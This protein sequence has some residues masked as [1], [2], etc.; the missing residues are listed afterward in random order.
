[1][2]QDFRIRSTDVKPNID[3]GGYRASD[4]MGSG[5]IPH[6]F[7]NPKGTNTDIQ[8]LPHLDYKSTIIFLLLF[9][10]GQKMICN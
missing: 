7:F 6:T 10:L 5:C 4:T 8:L 1:M 2:I 3:Q 9:V